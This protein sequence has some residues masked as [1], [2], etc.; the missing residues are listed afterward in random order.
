VLFFV[1]GAGFAQEEEEQK[2]PAWTGN[3]GLAY[4]ATSGNTDTET[5]G[6]DFKLE[7]EPEP[8][9]LELTALT[10]R[11]EDQGVKTA[12]RYLVG[13][14]V[15]RALDERWEA[16]AGLSAEQDEFSGFDLRAIV[17]VGVTYSALLGPTHVLSFDGGL[18]WT[19]EDRVEPELDV[20]S[21][22]GLLGLAYE[23]KISE[24]ASLTQRLVFYPNF[25]DSDD[26]RVNS[27][28]G[29]V[30]DISSLL[31]LKL[32]YEVRYRN[33]PIGSNDDT[34]TTTKVSLVVNF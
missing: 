12:E 25:D 16:F 21:L 14:R 2:E 28:T 11:A 31:A 6:L 33:L 4:L 29:L 30:A 13:A 5:F 10:N 9:G 1:V 15:R 34:D 8:W 17:E 27:D 22:G 26:W 3:L 19:D 32:S 20:D 23:W 18:T 7:R 24:T